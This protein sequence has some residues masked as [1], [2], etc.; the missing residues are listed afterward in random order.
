MQTMPSKSRTQVIITGV[1]LLV[2]VMGLII[3]GVSQRAREEAREID[4]ML[5]LA[6]PENGNAMQPGTAVDAAATP[7]RGAMGAADTTSL[8]GAA[9]AEAGD[10][11]EATP[12]LTTLMTVPETHV[13][14]PGETLYDISRK[15]YATHLHAGDIEQLNNLANPNQ[16]V[17]GMEL[18]LPRPEDLAAVGQ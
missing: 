7:D 16:I 1:A 6:E 9:T 4:P 11:A 5:E 2:L 13:V 17:A 3:Y 8:A 12:A 15:Y 18:K 10:Q 14:Q